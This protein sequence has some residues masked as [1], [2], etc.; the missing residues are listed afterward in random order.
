VLLVVD[1]NGLITHNE[2]YSPDDLDA[3]LD[4]LNRR[5]AA[6]LPP[7]HAAALEAGRA[8]IDL[9]NRQ[10]REGYRELVTDDFVVVDHR[11]M[12]WGTLGADDWIRLRHEL[13]DLAPDAHAIIA[14]VHRVESH[15]VASRVHIT[16]TDAHGGRFEMALESV[17]VVRDGRIARLEQFPAG[18]A[19]DALEHL[20]TWA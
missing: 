8:L 14:A 13:L 18:R 1:E 6:S 12:G 10:S 3:A 19:E 17:V 16:G 20:A 9:Y 2:W 15:G 11:P 7:E 5:Y 4:E